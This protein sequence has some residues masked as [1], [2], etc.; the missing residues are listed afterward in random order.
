MKPKPSAPAP[1]LA[2]LAP[3]LRRYLYF[4][5]AITGGA[6][7]IV[8]ILGAKM[9]APYLGTSHF[10]WTSQIAVTLVALACGYYAGGRLVDRSTRLGV[11]YV[12]ILLAGVYL[13]L[14]I[15][16][17]EP[18]A[19]QFLRM[20]LA[21]GSLLT[22]AV[23]Y[24][25]PL[26]LLAMVGPFFVRVL[27]SSVAGVGGNV[28]RLTA[29]ST[30]GSFTGTILIGYFLIPHLPNS[31]T[32]YL[33]S[34][35]LML[36]AVAYFLRWG[37]T[38]GDKVAV[39]V[40]VLGGIGLGYGG[41]EA[42]AWNGTVFD[43]L[44]RGNSNFGMLQV[45]QAKSGPRRLYLND[46]LTQNTYDVE[47]RKS[48]SMFTYM[49][50]GLAR[51]YVPRVTKVLC[52][53]MGVGIVPMEFARDGAQVDVAEIN[54]AV[55]PVAQKYFNF[56]PARVNLFIGDGRYFI[57]ESTN[58]YD[59][60]ILDAFLGD[61]CPSHLMTRE[62]FTAM[63][64]LLQPDGV[65]VM[66]TFADLS[67]GH[68]FFGASLYK[69]MT[70]VFGSVKIHVGRYG[71]TLYVGSPKTQLEFAH[72]PDYS[73]VYNGCLDEVQEAFA[74]VVEPEPGHGRVLTDDYNPVEYYDAANR[75]D[76]RR[77]LALGARE[78]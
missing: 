1:A 78:R 45:L 63:R 40:V 2:G 72:P 61:S 5:A 50:H 77:R 62:A 48:I 30:L 12:A 25:V 69:T 19:Y 38:T 13:A 54:P 22:S 10:V 51:A 73:D 58:R 27:T 17:R 8:E 20:R 39:G 6:I 53:G 47:Q 3:G 71:N 24:F 11:M 64:R 56:D 67:E 34:L 70:N 16:L 41:V 52:I 4:T 74:D 37:R 15:A 35:L 49:L 43:E 7:M 14:T 28:G 75:E 29:I 55:V 44:F 59:A 57:N 36:I 26:S 23:L 33:T 60:I 31:V 42:Q 9:L 46:Y 68:D 21:L 66:N 65:L 18:V 32:M 76:I